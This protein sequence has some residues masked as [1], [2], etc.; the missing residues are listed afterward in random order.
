MGGECASHGVEK[1]LIDAFA[2]ETWGI[3]ATW[4]T[5]T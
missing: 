2:G 1:R 3:E 5:Q 4:K